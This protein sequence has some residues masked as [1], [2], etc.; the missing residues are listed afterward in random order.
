MSVGRVVFPIL[1]KLPK[2]ESVGKPVFDISFLLTVA[3]TGIIEPRARTFE[4]PLLAMP[5]TSLFLVLGPEHMP[6]VFVVLSPSHPG[7]GIQG[8]LPRG[9]ITPVLTVS[10]DK[11]M[12]K[13][14]NIPREDWRHRY[15]RPYI[16][17][18]VSVDS[19]KEYN[20]PF[21]GIQ[22]WF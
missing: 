20:Y 18:C 12:A 17:C 5:S 1:Y 13:E 3:R 14:M 16:L 19:I 10:G 15:T 11:G 6:S 2:P 22:C 21:T 8:A 4:L 7:E 9:S